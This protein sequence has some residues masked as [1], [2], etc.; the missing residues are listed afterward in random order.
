VTACT[1]G[2]IGCPLRSRN[3]VKQEEKEKHKGKRRRRKGKE[4]IKKRI[5]RWK[6]DEC[7][8]LVAKINIFPHHPHPFLRMPHKETLF[9]LKG[10]EHEKE[11]QQQRKERKESRRESRDGN[12]MN[13]SNW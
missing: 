9:F 2:W 8:Q 4:G 7:K 12:T 5:K 1:K 13:A 6:H 3:E 11:K 10:K